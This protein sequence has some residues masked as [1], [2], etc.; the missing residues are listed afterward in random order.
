M[1]EGLSI[2]GGRDD[3]EYFDDDSPDEE[4]PGF[5]SG[6]GVVGRVLPRHVAVERLQRRRGRVKA[7]IELPPPAAGIEGSREWG[8]GKKE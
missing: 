1:R 4:L 2:T 7:G 5:S 6:H 8:S 3:L